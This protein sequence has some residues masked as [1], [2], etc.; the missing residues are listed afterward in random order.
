MK[1]FEAGVIRRL[2]DEG[3]LD[4]GFPGAVSFGGRWKFLTYINFVS[5]IL[6]YP[7]SVAVHDLV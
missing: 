2:V 4:K 5:T 7:T 1:V 6:R 3:N